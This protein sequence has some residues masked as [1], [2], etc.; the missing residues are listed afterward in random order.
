MRIDLLTDR[1]G[2][3]DAHLW[4]S[5]PGGGRSNV[6]EAEDLEEEAQCVSVLKRSSFSI[7]AS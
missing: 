7:S 2:H 5:S 6:A 3:E 1:H 4:D